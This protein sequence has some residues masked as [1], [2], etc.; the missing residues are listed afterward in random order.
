[1]KNYLSILLSLFLVFSSLSLKAAGSLEMQVEKTITRALNSYNKAITDND[2]DYWLRYFNKDIT[3][4]SPL[5]TSKNIDDLK[6]YYSLE[7]SNFD[8]NYETEQVI[9]KGRTAA[10]KL[11]W[12]I[13]K[14]SD[15]NFSKISIAAFFELSPSGKFSS[16]TFYFDTQDHVTLFK[17][18][19]K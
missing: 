5:K 14:K 16:A 18:M 10:A 4:S 12:N 11:V 9:A 2:P 17:E 6:N 19:L 7:F 1:M 3:F 8:A 13:K 15:A